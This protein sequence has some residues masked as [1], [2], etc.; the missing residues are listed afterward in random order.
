MIQA[1][2]GC[3]ST[4]LAYNGSSVNESSHGG[5]PICNRSKGLKGERFVKL[6][7][8]NVFADSHVTDMG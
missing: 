7:R 8:L 3:N 1:E 2:N 6:R 5:T 4:S